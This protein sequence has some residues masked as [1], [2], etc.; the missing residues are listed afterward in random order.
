MLGA[1]ALL[2]GASGC[3]TLLAGDPAQDLPT[4]P[5]PDEVDAGDA[6]VLE[7]IDVAPFNDSI[8]TCTS[9]A[10]TKIEAVNVGFNGPRSFR[11]TPDRKLGVY[12]V[13]KTGGREN[14]L[15]VGAMVE[16][17]IGLVQA[18][19][20]VNGLNTPDGDETHPMPS[21]DGL[22]L[23]FQKGMDSNAR[24]VV[25]ARTKITEPFSDE[26]VLLTNAREPYMLPNG[27]LYFTRLEGE[28]GI[29]RAE[30]A[31]TDANVTNVPLDRP[32]SFPVPSADER[33]LFVSIAGE[34]F[35]ATRA[36]TATAFDP[37]VHVPELNVLNADDRPTWLTPSGC[38]LF[39]TSNRG[40]TFRLY[41]ADRSP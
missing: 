31:L 15:N 5:P 25:A 40:G 20:L 8:S 14:D 9:G 3:G 34:I 22:R 10:F 6:G 38:V 36:T 1:A 4:R 18:P 26:V 32:A 35:V 33:T 37:V 23:F 29:R 16:S 19:S 27:A 41:R 28:D 13:V 7:A 30:G 24:V 17:T 39:F 12:S 21:A 2:L 11:F